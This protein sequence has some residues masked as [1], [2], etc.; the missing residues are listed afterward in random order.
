M[1]QRFYWAH[2][3][4]WADGSGAGAACM[5]RD[6]RLYVAT[7]MGVQVFDRNGR[8]RGIL[9]PAAGQATSICFGGANFKT[10]FVTS[11][12]KLYRRQMKAIGAPLFLAPIKLPLWGP[13]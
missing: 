13:A 3:P 8:S 6:G 7:S 9:P 4:E 11:G 10:L 12:G 5:D 1:K 2:M